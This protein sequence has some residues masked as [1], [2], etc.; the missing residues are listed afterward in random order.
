[1]TTL[2]KKSTPTYAVEK[3]DRNE[4]ITLPPPPLPPPLHTSSSVAKKTKKKTCDS[5]AKEEEE[6]EKERLAEEGLPAE[7]AGEELDLKAKNED[8]TVA[9]EAKEDERERMRGGDGRRCRGKGAGK[10]IARVL[11]EEGFGGG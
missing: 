9:C 10:Y 8:E 4:K 1:M 3:H 11:R 6:E 7:A 2:K 5:S